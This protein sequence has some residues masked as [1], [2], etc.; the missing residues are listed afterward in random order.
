MTVQ[1]RA[2][3]DALEQSA[4]SVAPTLRDTLPPLLLVEAE[5]LLRAGAAKYEGSDPHLDP[6]AIL[7]T[8][9]QL[10]RWIEKARDRD[11][12][13]LLQ[14]VPHA[15]TAE[16]QEVLWLDLFA[17]LIEHTKRTIAHGVIWIPRPDDVMLLSRAIDEALE[18]VERVKIAID[19]SGV[20]AEEIAGLRDRIIGTRTI[21]RSRAGMKLELGYL[22]VGIEESAEVPPAL[23]VL[24]PAL[25]TAKTHLTTAVEG[26][27]LP[28]QVKQ[29]SPEVH[30][31]VLA[32]VL[33]MDEFLSWAAGTATMSRLRTFRRII[34]PR[35]RADGTP[36]HRLDPDAPAEEDEVIDSSPDDD[37][38]DGPPSPSDDLVTPRRA[39]SSAENESSMSDPTPGAVSPSATASENAKSAT[40]RES[41]EVASP[42]SAAKDRAS[43]TEAS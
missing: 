39:R 18:L 8:A 4:V 7:K 32:L 12:T 42:N 20:R 15:T 24:V 22:R 17:T 41:D 5:R 23:R 16:P 26:K 19:S 1:T 38:E 2:T 34:A 36:V 6:E 37:E 29:Y 40:S 10:C 33:A 25:T 30:I 9:A 21:S 31:A 27:R 3:T 28:A 13:P 14:H 11:D 43:S 35:H